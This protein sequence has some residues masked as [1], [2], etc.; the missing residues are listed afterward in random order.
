MFQQF[1]LDPQRFYAAFIILSGILLSFGFANEFYLL[2]RSNFRQEF[3]SLSANQAQEIEKAAENS[4]S[5]IESIGAFYDAQGNVSRSQFGI[6]FEHVLKKEFP[7]IKMLQWAPRVLREEK[8]TWEENAI[9][10]GMRGF[11]FTERDAGGQFIAVSDREEY[12]PVY[13][14]ES[15]VAKE[16]LLGFDL[17]S[18]KDGFEVLEKAR[19]TAETVIVPSIKLMGGEPGTLFVFRPLFHKREAGKGRLQPDSY[20]GIL[21]AALSGPDLVQKVIGQKVLQQMD[22]V[23]WDRTVPSKPQPLY[24]KGIGGAEWAA[25][26][27]H[28]LKGR[29]DDVVYKYM[30]DV[31]NRQWEVIMMPRAEWSLV[32]HPWPL[33][34]FFGG[35]VVTLIGFY[36]FSKNREHEKEI[37]NQKAAMDHHAI[38]HKTDLGGRLTYVN[39][40]FCEISQYSR[41]DLLGQTYE[42]LRSDYHDK[43]FFD[44]MWLC[45]KGGM[46]WTGQVCNRAKDGTIFWVEMTIVPFFD[47]RGQPQEY[48]AICTDVT[49]NVENEK[50][51]QAA[52]QMKSDFISTVSHELR[53]PLASIKAALDVV[54]SGTAG[55]VSEDQDRFLGKAKAN[56][57]RLKR[58]IDDFLDLS[59]LE[60]G[61]VELHKAPTDMVALVNN[62]VDIQ[63]AVA[64]KKGLA[65]RSHMDG[66]L[67][68][69][70]CDADKISEVFI[71]FVNNA[72]KFTEKGEVVVEVRLVR[73]ENH[74]RCAVTDTGDGIA[75]EDLPKL[76]GKFQQLGDPAR[77][78]TGGTGLGLAIC[79]EIVTR[80]NG[81]IWVES[82]KGKG[83][84]F[85]FTLPI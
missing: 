25:I 76:F 2:E 60:S 85:I 22:V 32:D 47:F 38:V 69:I 59:K 75:A 79:K 82:E 1:R 66:A 39:D 36:V 44:D 74:V 12:F 80:H 81:R 3:G 58:L 73:E 78:K 84:S 52:M 54:L 61:I 68:L 26:E 7:Y 11:R 23:I 19:S 70:T 4:L 29:P 62:V 16:Q 46:I 42:I 77:R 65:L 53:T 50:K 31:G 28:S 9:K 48:I 71:N 63:K 20:K 34:I 18:N 24:F 6:F 67:P 41:E 43:D 57:D 13:Y 15:R 40:K 21:L 30:V 49:R 72:I 64:E 35:M 10:D 33:I 51:I 14:L 37:K 45:I 83:S 55:T 27:E 17:A 8:A 56:I 5:A